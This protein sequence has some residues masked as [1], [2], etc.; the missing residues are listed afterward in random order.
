M[1]DGRVSPSFGKLLITRA[2]CQHHFDP[3]ISKAKLRSEYGTVG[4][5]LVGTAEFETSFEPRK[6]VSFDCWPDGDEKQF[7]PD[8][9]N[10]SYVPVRPW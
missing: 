7:L 5:D 8:P 9:H 3:S 1:T 10:R 4:T 2:T 6:Q